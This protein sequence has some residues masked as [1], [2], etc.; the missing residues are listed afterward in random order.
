MAASL[1]TQL[2]SYG[3]K[4][5]PW[6]FREMLTDLRFNLYPA[7]SDERLTYNP[8]EAKTYCHEVRAKVG[9]RFPDEFILGTLAGIRKHTIKA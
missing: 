2:R 1:K 3:C 9:L 7:W 5:E 8:D 6:Q 4:M